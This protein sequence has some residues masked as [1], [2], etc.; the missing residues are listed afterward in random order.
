LDRKAP[1]KTKNCSFHLINILF[2]DEIS[3]EFLTI[4]ARKDKDLIDSG[5]AANDEYF[6]QE[7]TEKLPGG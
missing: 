2:S 3:H 6:W 5:L 4:G 1:A 7:V